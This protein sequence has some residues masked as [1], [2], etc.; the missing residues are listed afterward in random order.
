[1]N[2]NGSSGRYLWINIYLLDRSKKGGR[3]IHIIG[4]PNQSGRENI[5]HHAVNIQN[6]ESSSMVKI[7]NFMGKI[8]AT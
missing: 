5:I 1:M 6:Q 2:A 4:N 3:I 7:S 8:L